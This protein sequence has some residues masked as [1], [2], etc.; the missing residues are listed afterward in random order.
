MKRGLYAQLIH[1]ALPIMGANLLQT[2]YNLA[3]SYFLG[4]LGKEA[5]SAP[6]ISFNIIIFLI[7][8]GAGFSSAGTTL[9]SQAK[10]REDAD[11]VEFYVGQTFGILVLVSFLIMITGLL[12]TDPLLRLLQVPTGL[13]YEY[14]KTYMR[15]IFYGMP[16]MFVAFA[17]RGILQGVGD[18]LT[19]LKIQ[20][21]TVSLN[22]GLDYLL[23]F[24]IGPF[25][26]MGVAG[27]AWATVISRSIASVIDIYLLS[28]GRLKIRL[29]M[30]TIKPD[31]RAWGLIMSIGLP[32]S[33]GQG[34]SALGFTT[35]QG[36]VNT[37]GPAVIAAFGVGGRI[38]ALFNMP[39]Q[40]ISQATAV[41]VGQNLGAK[42]PDRAVQVVRYGLMTIA[43][44]IIAGMSLTFFYG[45]LLVR[46]FVD[47]PEV[48][49]YGATL[50]RIVSISVVFFALYTVLIG[51]F[52]GGGDTK[53]IMVVQISRLWL[54][55]VP[56][57]FFLTSIVHMGPDGIWW[58]MF[59]S[60]FVVAIV[61]WLLYRTG[62]W[63]YR[64]NSDTI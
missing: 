61:V 35:L 55:R 36:I 41:L 64:L 1:L 22:V 31:R 53:P 43:V 10:G 3:D 45:N 33:I 57:A 29:R 50:F 42:A 49:F 56:V 4:K 24:G 44:F 62:R 38:I 59:A 54:I 20:I 21:I 16:F 8:F 25:P 17:F 26:V 51:A 6:S 11:K 39:A 2:L 5:I 60:N 14:T 63:K 27:A 32:S 46:F 12:L 40:G 37:F 19:P 23:I 9:I 28:S 18:S 7:I 47:D 52:Q 58:G 15:I 34:V 48:I 30:S 13:T